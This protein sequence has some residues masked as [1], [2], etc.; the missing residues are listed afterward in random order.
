LR[1]GERKNCRGIARLWVVLNK[2]AAKCD[3]FRSFFSE[4]RKNL[5][6]SFGGIYGNG[7]ELERV[8]GE[9]KGKQRTIWERFVHFSE[10]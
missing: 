4:S 3:D 2:E 8:G 1:E 10:L 6:R 5:K 7:M 9:L